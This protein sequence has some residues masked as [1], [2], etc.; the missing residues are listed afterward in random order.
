M[1]EVVAWYAD[2]LATRAFACD[3]GWRGRLAD[4]SQQVFSELVEH[5]CPAC[6]TALVVREFPTH[7]EVR[8]AARRGHPDAVRDL[9]G[10]ERAAGRTERAKASELTAAD[11]LPELHLSGPTTFVWDLEQREEESWTVVRLAGSG[12]EVW[13][14]LA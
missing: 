5:D 8:E 11:Q 3:C 9:P 4:M 10:S 6:D 7:D 1:A 2:G 13:R 12:T 14:E